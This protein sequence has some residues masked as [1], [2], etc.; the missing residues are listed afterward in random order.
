MERILETKINSKLIRDL[1]ELQKE[2]SNDHY[3]HTS[4]RSANDNL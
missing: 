3:A 1:Q 2:I 4:K